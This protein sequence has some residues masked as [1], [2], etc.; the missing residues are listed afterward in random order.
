MC[1]DK[2][3]DGLQKLKPRRHTRIKEQ[4]NIKES[5]QKKLRVLMYSAIQLCKTKTKLSNS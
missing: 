4:A 3:R 2:A 5:Y 1:V